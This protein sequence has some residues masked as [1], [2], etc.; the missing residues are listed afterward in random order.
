MG[1]SD[2]NVFGLLS[3]LPSSVRKGAVCSRFRFRENSPRNAEGASLHSVAKSPVGLCRVTESL[4]NMCIKM[5]VGDAVVTAAELKGIFD[6]ASTIYVTTSVF[7]NF[8][9]TLSRCCRVRRRLYYRYPWL[10]QCFPI[11]CE[12]FC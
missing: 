11:F 4:E 3:R 6:S 10:S 8:A 2:W 5:G 12:R 1:D 7:Q 9:A